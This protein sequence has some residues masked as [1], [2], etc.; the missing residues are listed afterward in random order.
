MRPGRNSPAIA[1]V[2]SS[3]LVMVLVVSILYIGREILIPLALAML[4]TFLLTPLVSRLERWPGRVAAVVLV[5][6]IL[7]SLLGGAG[8]LLTRQVIDLATKLSDYQTNIESKLHAFRMPTSGVFGRFQ[9]S[10]EE[11]KEE[12]PGRSSPPEADRNNADKKL[13]KQ[14]PDG[15]TESLPVPVRVVESRGIPQLLSETTRAMDDAARRVARYLTMQCVVNIIREREFREQIV[16]SPS[17][18]WTRIAHKLI[19][20]IFWL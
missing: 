6:L 1:L 5:V 11:I 2:G 10:V 14:F 4:I 3:I 16:G 15:V 7:F 18:P 12:L 19:P 9:K 20:S 17:R 8:W 13:A